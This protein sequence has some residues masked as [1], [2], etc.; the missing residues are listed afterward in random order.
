MGVGGAVNEGGEV[1][2]ALELVLQ[3]IQRPDVD[4]VM[5]PVE[6]LHSYGRLCRGRKHRICNVSKLIETGDG[7]DGGC[8]RS[9]RSTRCYGE[10]VQ[11]IFPQLLAIDQLVRATRV[12]V[13]IKITHLI[14]L[15]S[16]IRTAF[17]NTISAMEKDRC[18]RHLSSTLRM[19]RSCFAV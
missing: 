15:A 13:S 18:A 16:L 14:T 2:H 10:I 8:R 9:K 19:R 4:S 12:P 3:T 17:D 11:H 1:A 7:V 5:S 6:D